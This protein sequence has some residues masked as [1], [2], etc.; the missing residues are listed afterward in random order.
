MHAAPLQ[1]RVERN[2]GYVYQTR[3]GIR[4]ELG[5]FLELALPTERLC[6]S[7]CSMT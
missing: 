5:G 2:L 7:S 3:G 4:L 6:G 1:L